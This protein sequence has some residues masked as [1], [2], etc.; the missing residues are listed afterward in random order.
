MDGEALLGP[1]PPEWQFSTR[2][3]EHTGAEWIGYRLYGSGG[4]VCED[5]RLEELTKPWRR[6]KHSE[7]EYW[8]WF[9]N[10]E[11]G[12]DMYNSDPRLTPQ[13]L[14]A[15]GIPLRTFDLI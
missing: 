15:K 1:L 14:R 2:L 12:E 4:F 10:E 5:P 8:T 13:A 3:H 11:T 7:E 9:L 6:R